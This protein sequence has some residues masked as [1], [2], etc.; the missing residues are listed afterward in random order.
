MVSCLFCFLCFTS[1]VSLTSFYTEDEPTN[2]ITISS[3]GVRSFRYKIV[4]IQVDSIPI[5]VVSRHHQSRFESTQPLCF[6]LFDRRKNCNPG[7]PM[8]MLPS[9]H[10]YENTSN[11][12][13][14]G[15]AG[16]KLQK[17][18]TSNLVKSNFE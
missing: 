7:K 11:T 2:G 9:A 15:G 16:Q 10:S 13:F 3:N 8:K 5:K 14:F 1:S 17:S 4:S 12:R 18:L 6:Q